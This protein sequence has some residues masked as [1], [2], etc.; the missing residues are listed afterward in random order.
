MPN[1]AS[2]LFGLMC[3]VGLSKLHL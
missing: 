1:H 2:G 3:C